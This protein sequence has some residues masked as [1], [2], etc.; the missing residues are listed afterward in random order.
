MTPR[1]QHHFLKQ[2]IAQMRVARRELEADLVGRVAAMAARRGLT[3]SETEAVLKG[4]LRM[5]GATGTLAQALCQPH[6]E[7]PQPPS[8]QSPRQV[9]LS[10][11]PHDERVQDLKEVRRSAPVAKGEEVACPRLAGAEVAREEQVVGAAHAGQ[12]H[13][14]HARLRARKLPKSHSGFCTFQGVKA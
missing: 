11:S 4:P 2:R 14:E 6:Q 9:D 3:A 13:E 8:P 5:P 12:R 10:G 7:K 1:L